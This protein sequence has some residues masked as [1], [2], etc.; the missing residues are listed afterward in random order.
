MPVISKIFEKVLYSR[1]FDY[2]NT[3]DFLYEHQYGFRPHSNTL[4]ATIDLVT[5]IKNNI[6]KKQLFL[7]IFIELKKAFDTISHSILL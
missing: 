5:K 2:L 6:D 7:G 3:I 4:A 1:L